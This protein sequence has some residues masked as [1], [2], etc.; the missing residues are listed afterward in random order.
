MV[1][2]FCQDYSDFPLLFSFL[3]GFFSSTSSAGA[4]SAGASASAATSLDFFGRFFGRG[5][6]SRAIFLFKAAPRI[7]PSE[8]L[9]DD[10]IV[11]PP[12]FPRRFQAF[13]D[14]P[15]RRSRLSR[16][17]TIAS[18]LLPTL[19]RSG[20]WFA[21]ARQVAAADRPKHPCR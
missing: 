1:S 8:A 2:A 18:I 10:H 3:W 20:R 7:S 5:F 16:L 6:L 12:L 11:P 17:V 19:N 13:I 4:S 21:V 9:S 14:R 15:T